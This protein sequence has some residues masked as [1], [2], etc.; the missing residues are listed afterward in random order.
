MI[1][2][3]KVF[4]K[5]LCLFNMKQL[6]FYLLLVLAGSSCMR[7]VSLTVLQPAQFT[8]P[9]HIAK[10]AVVDRS[11]PS[12]GWLNVLEGVLTGEAIGQDRRSREEAVA[13]LTEGLRNTPRFQ[14]V[15]TGIEMTGTRAGNNMPAPL[16]WSEVERICREHQADAVVTIESFDSDN[17]VTTQRRQN[18]TKDK[19]GKEIIT[20]HFDSDMRTGVRMGWRMYDPKNKTIIDEFVTDDFIRSNSTGNSERDAVSRLPAPTSVSRRV[21]FMGGQ[22]YGMRIAPTYVRVSRSYYAKAKGV[23]SEMKQAAR[24]AQSGSWDKAAGIWS[25]LYETNKKSSDKVAGRA[26][27]NMAIAAEMKGNLV[28]ALEWAKKSWEVHGNKQARNYIYTLQNRL[29]D[30]ERVGRQM[31]EKT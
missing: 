5:P 21:A 4:L 23:K 7:S 20:I 31:H 15:R 12:N 30:Q 1:V 19:N 6:S 18:K 8:V 11:K 16:P 26:A 24:Y 14:V 17:A 3:S 2:R 29:D 10:I 27:Y 22:H 25:R 9:E 13:G 28:V